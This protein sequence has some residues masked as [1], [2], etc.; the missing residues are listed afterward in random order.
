MESSISFYKNLLGI[1]EIVYDA[2]STF[3][4]VPNNIDNKFRR[5]ILKKEKA[6][7][8]A[9]SNLLGD[10]EIE[11]AQC[12]DK[13]TKRIFKNR[14][15]GDLGFIHLCFDV[16]DMDAL[17]TL[18]E[19]LGYNFTVDSKDSYAM[20]AAKG[21]FCY[22][23]DPDGTLIELVETHKI[24]IVKKINWHIDLKKRM[25]QKPLPSWMIN[26]LGVNKVR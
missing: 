9:F 21:R 2:T 22:V 3:T 1:D 16:T 12:I 26:M 8:G 13:K 25:N 20:E 23:E 5:V 19:K 24:P 6:T 15:W 11:L 4:D 17:K 7:C 14:Y 10:V 18:S